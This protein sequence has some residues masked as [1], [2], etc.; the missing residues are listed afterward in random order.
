MTLD[1]EL[2]A[3]QSQAFISPATE[4]LYGGAAGGGKSHLMRVASIAWC[5]DIPGL[6]VYLFR[7][8]SN[9]LV[10]NHFEGPT[11]YLALLSDWIGQ[12]LVR[13]NFGDNTLAFWNGSKIFLNHCQHEKDKYKYQGAE[14]HVLMIDELTHFTQSIYTF[15][16]GRVRMT[17]LKLPEH[18][19]ERFPRII[20]GSN[21]GGVGHNWVKAAFIDGCAPM[22]IRRMPKKDGGM[23][24]QYI[25]AKLAD[26]PTLAESDPDYVDRLEGLSSPDLVRAMKEGD[27][28]IISGGMFDDVWR[29]DVHVI[30]P[31]EVPEGWP[32]TRAFDW[33]SSKPFVVGWFTESD[34]VQPVHGRVYPRGTVFVIHEWYGWNGT[35]DVGLKLTNSEIARGIKERERE[36]GIKPMPGPADSAIFSEYN[37]SSIA[38]DMAAEGVVWVPADKRPGSRING[39]EAIR[40][41]LKASMAEPMELPGLI[42]TSNCQQ[43]IRTVPVLPRDESKPDDVMTAAE[44]HWGDCL[45]YHLGIS[46]DLQK[47]WDWS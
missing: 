47:G 35:P 28:D 44:D 33:G 39:W 43:F 25:P 1:L 29:R 40:Q 19:C 45:R 11:G 8:L 36:W 34:G 37:G 24:R 30:E 10:K 14:I 6:Q 5:T 7:R 41:R 23:L 4:I 9:D 2:H 21:P 12:K 15:L 18:W 16:R 26:N 22:E 32:I 38:A 31:F 17:G 20:C 42:V 46:N 3:R 27:W 13:T